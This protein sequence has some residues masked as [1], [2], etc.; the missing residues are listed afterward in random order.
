ME[1][2]FKLYLPKDLT[3]KSI[4]KLMIDV[5]DKDK[6]PI[7]KKVTIDFTTLSFIQPAGV[8]AIDNMISWLHKKDVEVVFRHFTDIHNNKDVTKYLD[9]SGFFKKYLGEC[10]VEDANLRPTT[11]PLQNVTYEQ[12]HSWLRNI[13]T[14]WLAGQLNVKISTLGNIEM[15]LGE[16][17]NNIQDHSYENIGC[18]Y[19]QHFP[20]K[21][22]LTFCIADFGVGIPYNVRKVHPEYTDSEALKQAIVEGFTTKTSPRNLG[23]G[24]YTMIKNVVINLRGSVHINSGYGILDVYSDNGKIKSRASENEGFYPGTFLEFNINTDEVIKEDAFIEEEEFVW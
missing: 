7:Y 3:R 22:L 8:V 21:K 14:P 12:S 11:I 9:D 1:P 5:L 4:N 20:Q 19:A 23:A 24:L 6:E 13:F 16:I 15:C 18:L 17:F 2:N 10:L